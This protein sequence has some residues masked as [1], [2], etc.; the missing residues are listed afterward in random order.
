MF[1]HYISLL[2]NFNLE[3]KV[4]FKKVY[5]SVMWGYYS[6]T[7]HITT[8]SQNFYY[9]NLFFSLKNC[10]LN[11]GEIYNASGYATLMKWQ[12]SNNLF[13]SSDVII[14]VSRRK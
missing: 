3:Q 6:M 8:C 2:L 14:D 5:M 10:Y 13:A 9:F 12:I 4:I 7:L 11:K 1:T